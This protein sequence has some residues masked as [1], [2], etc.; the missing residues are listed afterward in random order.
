MNRLKEILVEKGTISG[1]RKNPLQPLLDDH[2]VS[3]I[4][5]NGPLDIYTKREGKKTKKEH[6]S[7][8]D[9]EHIKDVLDRISDET[10][11][12]ITRAEATV[13]IEKK[14]L[15]DRKAL[16]RNKSLAGGLHNMLAL[17]TKARANIVITGQSGT[18]KS[19]LL[20][21]LLDETGNDRLVVIDPKGE[22]RP[23]PNAVILHRTDNALDEALRLKAETIAINDVPVCLPDLLD[24]MLSGVNCIFTL[25]AATEDCARDLLLLKSAETYPNIPFKI[26]KRLVFQTMDILVRMKRSAYLFDDQIVAEEVSAFTIGSSPYQKHETLYLS[27]LASYGGECAN[28]ALPCFI[29]KN[30]GLTSR[31][32]DKLFSAGI[33]DK[34]L[35]EKFKWEDSR[36]C[37]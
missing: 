30:K 11:L 5:I 1:E 19:T 9:H 4:Y 22:I 13:I 23:R 12:R 17:F 21:T 10:P 34:W 35:T 24:I 2:T 16:D 8:A 31:L 28:P 37:Y 25:E 26:L 15:L 33:R 27:T 36:S 3:E 29:Y 32:R 20:D 14:R 6:A 7:F 18:L